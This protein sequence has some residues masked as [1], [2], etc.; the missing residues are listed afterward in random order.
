MSDPKE[1]NYNNGVHTDKTSGK[2]SRR[3]RQAPDI[4]QEKWDAIFKSKKCNEKLNGTKSTD[5][6]DTKEPPK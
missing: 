2:G 6:Q 3:R 4:P 1:Y 5:V